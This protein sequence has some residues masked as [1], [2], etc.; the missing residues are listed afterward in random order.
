MQGQSNDYG[1][2]LHEYIPPPQQNQTYLELENSERERL[3]VLLAL[4]R[5]RQPAA[6]ERVPEELVGQGSISARPPLAQRLG[7]RHRK[8]DEGGVE[9]DP[10]LVARGQ[11]EGRA[12]YLCL[13]RRN[14]IVMIG[15]GDGGSSGG[16]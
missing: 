11:L 16:L 5:L 7:R 4:G 8:P 10:D 15:G 12:V 1:M 14:T 9:R 3:V 6:Q 13:L 2:S